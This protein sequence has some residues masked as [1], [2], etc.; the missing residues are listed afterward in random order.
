MT[1]PQNNQ[2]RRTGLIVIVFIIIAALGYFSYEFFKPKVRKIIRTVNT[3][4]VSNNISVAILDAKTYANLK[5]L[6]VTLVDPMDKIVA[7]NGLDFDEIKVNDGIFNLAFKE[8][9]DVSVNNPYIFYLLIES[10]EENYIPTKKTFIIPEI[11]EQGIFDMV[12]LSNLNNPPNGMN[13]V[14]KIIPLTE[15]AQ[16]I[17]STTIITSEDEANTVKERAKL[18]IPANTTLLDKNG[19]PIPNP[20]K[21]SA[22]LRIAYANPRSLPV[23]LAYPGGYILTEKP[24]NYDAAFEE[25]GII[26]DERQ[27]VEAPA[28][29]PQKPLFY[30]KTSLGWAYFEMELNDQ[31]VKKFDTSLPATIEVD[32]PMYNA[33]KPILNL[34]NSNNKIPIL[35]YNIGE[36]NWIKETGVTLQKSDTLDL[37]GKIN[38][39]FEIKHFSVW[40]IGTVD[41][42][43][44]NT[45]VLNITHPDQTDNA[46]VPYFT[47]I[48]SASNPNHPFTIL[49]GPTNIVWYEPG[50]SKTINVNYAPPSR[51]INL[52]VTDLTSPSD[53]FV[54]LLDQPMIFNTCGLPQF[55]D[56]LSQN[57]SI[58]MDIAPIADEF[59]CARIQFDLPLVDE[60]GDPVKICNNALWVKKCSTCS[61]CPDSLYRNIG[62][63][64]DN[65]ILTNKLDLTES[66]CMKI[67]FIQHDENGN[68]IGEQSID[69]S[70]DLNVPR[71]DEFFFN[72]NQE[73]KI[74][75]ITD[76]ESGCGADK[77]V[78]DIQVI[79]SNIST[80]TTCN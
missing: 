53:L 10:L 40:E 8:N 73:V 56:C 62:I 75:K 43:C 9:V 1:T 37:L 19:T 26:I 57:G 71:K 5:G 23:S 29:A 78:L 52:L 17:K 55:S 68:N 58:E 77:Y 28:P 22:I 38:S 21:N 72:H 24:I 46:L 15:E 54:N 47:K 39:N 4:S 32:E 59:Q 60:N 69:F 66:Y 12:F 45:L 61:G 44:S 31:K 27:V 41:T 63:I 35:S 33:L 64:S 13:V 11:P 80:I 67:W 50:K 65:Q 2:N 20:D 36:D 25:G 76:T 3:V 18:T 49:N 70:I 6:K 16:T 14:T 42:G 79:N 48:V 7:S 74:K 30:F 34:P 51:C